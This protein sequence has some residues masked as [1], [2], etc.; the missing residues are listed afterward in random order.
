MTTQPEKLQ[1]PEAPPQVARLESIIREFNRTYPGI[2]DLETVYRVVSQAESVGRPDQ[3]G[4]AYVRSYLELAR[5]QP[6]D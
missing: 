2:D 6:E 4:R 3:T 5:A 1:E